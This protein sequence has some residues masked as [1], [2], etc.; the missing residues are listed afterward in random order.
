MRTGSDL[1][2]VITD[3]YGRPLA[4][5]DSKEEAIARTVKQ[6]DLSE[7]QV[8]ETLP[9]FV[10]PAINVTAIRCI[11]KCEEA[12]GHSR[13][14]LCR[15]PHG[16]YWLIEGNISPSDAHKEWC[17]ICIQIY[18]LG[19]SVEQ[20]LILSSELDEHPEGYE[21][22]CNCRN[23]CHSEIPFRSLGGEIAC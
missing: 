21:G 23:L 2:H 9:Y 1:I 19:K 7:E 8:R 11:A 6:E 17:P 10:Y 13:G 18:S 4:C 16:H 14:R 3:D 22:P 12:K 5:G 20:L 15:C